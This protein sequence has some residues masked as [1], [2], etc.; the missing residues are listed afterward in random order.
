M[1]RGQALGGLGQGCW[2][3]G[4]DLCLLLLLLLLQW[5]RKYGQF[6]AF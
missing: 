5:S 3:K 6:K 2:S 4:L 1:A